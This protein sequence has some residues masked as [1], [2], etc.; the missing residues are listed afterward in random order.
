MTDLD[1]KYSNKYE[2]YYKKSDSNWRFICALDKAE[3]IINLTN[4]YPHNKI[5]EIGAGDGSI[6]KILD[7]R[8]FGDKYTA[9]DISQSAIDKINNEKI[10]KLDKSQVFDGYSLP[11]D[12][13]EFDLVILS[14]VI[15]HLEYPRKL[16]YESIR[17]GK[18]IFVEVP[19]EDN[20]RLSSNYVENETGHI[21]FYNP[22]TIRRL[23]QTCGLRLL[24]QQLSNPSFRVYKYTYGKKALLHYL[25]KSIALKLSKKL[26]S[27]FFTY[28]YSTILESN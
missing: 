16:I 11:F 7:K 6:L 26:A 19:C 28:H 25:P 8:D 20:M 23:L 14:H 27:K 3:N 1:K 4:K 12:S 5:L 18:H 17:V 2:N 22:N 21:N 9:L 24:D 15:E 13:S 10:K